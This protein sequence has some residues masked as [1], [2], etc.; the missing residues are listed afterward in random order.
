MT[1]N[2]SADT[3][4]ANLT[5]NGASFNGASFTV[6]SATITFGNTSSVAT[7]PGSCTFTGP[8]AVNDTAGL[9]GFATTGDLVFSAAAVA[10]SA[11]GYIN[12]FSPI[13]N[14]QETLPSAS[15]ASANPAHLPSDSAQVFLMWDSTTKQVLLYPGI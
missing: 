5:F 11:S 6:N 8:F 13:I 3:L 9:V 12:V 14:I 2:N 1:I 15:S 10:F 7:F 4:N